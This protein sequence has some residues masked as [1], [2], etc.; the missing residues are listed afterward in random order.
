MTS[1]MDT[2]RTMDSATTATKMYSRWAVSR[3]SNG[4]GMKLRRV[5]QVVVV[6]SSNAVL[7]E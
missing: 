3:D 7:V 6:E 5:M 4:D 2:N 1:D